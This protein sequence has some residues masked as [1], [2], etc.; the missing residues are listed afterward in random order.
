MLVVGGFRRANP[1]QGAPPRM[2]DSGWDWAWDG[3][4]RKWHVGD[5]SPLTFAALMIGH[6]F[7]ISA[8]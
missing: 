7:S 4:V 2:G 5:Y 1:D 6:H 3:V 8:L